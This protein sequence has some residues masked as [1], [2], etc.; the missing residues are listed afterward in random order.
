MCHRQYARGR[1][2]VFVS[3]DTMIYRDESFPFGKCFQNDET[4]E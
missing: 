3:F 4:E 1:R 2:A